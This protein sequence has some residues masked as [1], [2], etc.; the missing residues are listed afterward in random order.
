MSCQSSE[1][2]GGS[3]CRGLENVEI[4]VPALALACFWPSPVA[5]E[6]AAPRL[7]TP[8]FDCADRGRVMVRLHQ[9]FSVSGMVSHMSL[10]PV[11]L[12]GPPAQRTRS[13]MEATSVVGPACTKRR[14][15]LAAEDAATGSACAS[16]MGSATRSPN[17]WSG[18]FR[19]RRASGRGNSS[20][21]GGPLSYTDRGN[22]R[23]HRN[24]LRRRR[25]RSR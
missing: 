1:C 8:Q 3:A 18:P 14:R 4:V 17:A 13:S 16:R 15:P 20:A 19:S 2:K 23:R 22:K 6:A 12:T 9:E 11:T 21:C 10:N 24:S 7:E 5:A 25:A